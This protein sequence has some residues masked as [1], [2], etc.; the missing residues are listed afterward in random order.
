ML[1][2]R[3]SNKQI[4]K[5][6]M[7][8]KSGLHRNLHNYL[9]TMRPEVQPFNGKWSLPHRASWLHFKAV[10]RASSK[11]G[12]SFDDGEGVA[13]PCPFYRGPIACS[14]PQEMLK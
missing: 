3:G 12:Y 14:P 13:K 11:E 1:C 9:L 5:P 6:T 2:L 7:E 10:S 8:G 4:S